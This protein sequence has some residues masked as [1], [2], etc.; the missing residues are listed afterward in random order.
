MGAAGA[1]RR[2]GLMTGSLE[3]ADSPDSCSDDWPLVMSTSVLRSYSAFRP[4]LLAPGPAGNKDASGA[5]VSSSAA[6]SVKECVSH[7]V[8]EV[9]AAGMA[10]SC[11]R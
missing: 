7:V 8:E 2:R 11:E 3:T 4:V 1:A 9:P 5:L 10:K 6:A